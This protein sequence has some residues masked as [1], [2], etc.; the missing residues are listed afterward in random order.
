[1]AGITVTEI[2]KEEQIAKTTDRTIMPMNS[3]AGPGSMAIGAKASAVV[4]V[5]APS[6]AKR[7]F[8]LRSMASSRLSPRTRHWSKS[9]TTTMALSISRPSEMTSPVTD[10]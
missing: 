3:P 1:M 8:R 2:R 5:E 6:G 10:I 7:C 4:S 9:S